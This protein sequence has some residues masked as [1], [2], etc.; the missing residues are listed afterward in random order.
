MQDL[1]KTTRNAGSVRARATL[2]GAVAVLMW[3]SLAPLTA[4]A[5]GIPPLQLLATTFGIAFFSGLA[6]LL[7]KGWHSLVRRL[8]QPLPYLGFATAALFGYHALYFAALSLAPAAQASLVAYLWPLLIVL[9]SMLNRRA[10]PTR[11]GHVAG[12][13]LGLAGTAL[14]ILTGAGGNGTFP[15]RPLGLLAALSCAFIWSGYSVLNRRFRH[16]SSDAMVEVCGLVA[17]L[18]LAA[19]LLLDRQTVPPSVSQW[20]AITALGVGPVGLAFLAWD[21]GTKHGDLG[22]LSAISYAAPVLS[23]LLLVTLGYAP[24]TLN[25]LVACALVVGGAWIAST[26]NRAAPQLQQ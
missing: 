1:G 19:H 10:H 22:L 24:A 2:I 23:T 13:L 3:S 11:P 15:N 12:A 16:V 14:L 21:Y 17:A 20:A 26:A 25:L 8:R 7:L 6:W 18:G 4:A 5:G 9:L